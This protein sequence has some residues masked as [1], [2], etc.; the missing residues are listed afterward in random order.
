MCLV[1]RQNRWRGD[2]G[3]GSGRANAHLGQRQQSILGEWSSLDSN[4]ENERCP[5]CI[6]SVDG[7]VLVDR[8]RGVVVG[9]C[10]SRVK[11]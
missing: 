3:F 4:L 11:G 9:Y 7:A 8:E 1:C 10:Q 6:P 2:T 5:G